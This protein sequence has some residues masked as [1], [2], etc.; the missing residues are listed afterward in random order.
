M[1][2][3]TRFDLNAAIDNWRNELA[4]QPNLAPDDRRELETHL[5]DA[6]ARFQQQGLNDEESFCLA[7]HRVGQPQQIGE[8]FVKANTAAVGANVPSGGIFMN[9]NLYKD[10]LAAPLELRVFAIFSLVVTILGLALP[11]LGPKH[12]LEYIIPFTG[13]NPALGYM[14]G[15]IM[16]FSI[17]YIYAK[18]PPLLLPSDKQSMAH[19]ALHHLY[20]KSVTWLLRLGLIAPL[21]VQIVFGLLYDD[22]LPDNNFGNPYLTVSPWRPVWTV[23]I[24]ALWIAILLMAP[25]NRRTPKRA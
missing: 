16:S 5:R 2:N 14:S 20:T 1:E 11:I 6:I 22:K 13:W 24:P 21:A 15:L 19:R 18:F 23:L 9:F 25:Q 10:F 7:R 3:Q 17:I 4:A 12:L 8:E